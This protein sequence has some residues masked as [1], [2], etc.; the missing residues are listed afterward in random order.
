MEFALRGGRINTDAIDNSA[1]VD[2]SDHEVNIKILLNAV[3][4]RGEC[5]LQGRNALLAEM[6]DE[7][8]RTL[9]LRDN[10]RQTQAICRWRKPQT[11]AAAKSAW[12]L[13]AGAGA[14]RRELDPR[15]SSTCHANNGDDRGRKAA[16]TGA[17]AA[18]AGGA[19]GLCQDDAGRGAAVPSDLPD[20]PQL[21]L[22]IMDLAISKALLQASF[23]GRTRRHRLGVGSSQP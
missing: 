3:V 20:D 5:R 11:P 12:Q 14:G 23:T 16:G 13:H 18:G 10:Y 22:T 15:R 7:R 19:A 9:V 21:S 6:T 17:D 2:T 8:G 4:A 1:G